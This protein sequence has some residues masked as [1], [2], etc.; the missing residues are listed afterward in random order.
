MMELGFKTYK[1]SVNEL[2]VTLDDLL[3]MLH[4][5]DRTEDNP[6]V[7]EALEVFDQLSD[8]ADI[9][10]GYSLFEKFSFDDGADEVLVNG[11]L[12]KPSGK[13]FRLLEG[14][15]LLA[16]VVCTAGKGFTEYTSVY[17]SEGEYLKSYIA[18]A[19]GSLV[20]EKS[21]EY[22]QD[23]LQDDMREIG[24]KLTNRYSPGYCNWP[25]DDQKPLFS[26]LPENV[27][28]ITLSASCLMSPIKSVS[29][30]VGVGHDVRRLEYT[31]DICT[32]TTCV[33]RKVRN[34]NNK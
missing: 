6:V 27:C 16:I 20:A 34:K 24:M 30:I 25:V 33:Y 11:V 12:L 14:S 31:C 23:R 21:I 4:E 32:N 22:I 3:D 10:G 28:G 9:C 17:N 7:C 18:D 13:I 8:I 2:G 26:L 19:L 29:G 15:E 1:P 5:E